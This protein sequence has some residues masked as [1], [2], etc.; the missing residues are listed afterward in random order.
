MITVTPLAA[1]KIRQLLEKNHVSG[2]LRLGVVGGGCSGLT[3]KFKFES[4]PRAADQVFE[5]DGVKVF[6]DPKSYTHLD[7]LTLDY[8]ESLMESGFVFKNPN[9]QHSCSCGKSFAL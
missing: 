4:E 8:H 1:T 2:G 6:V 7:G 9:A 5:V 3:Y